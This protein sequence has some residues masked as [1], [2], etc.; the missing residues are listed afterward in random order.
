MSRIGSKPIDVPSGVTVKVTGSKVDV[1]GAKG[2]MSLDV[3]EP[4]S[5]KL[6]GSIVTLSR[7][8][9]VKSVKALH[10]L[11]RSLL[12]NIIEGVSNGFEKKLELIGVGYRASL[13]GKNLNLALGYSHPVKLNAPEGITFEV[14]KK[15]TEIVVKGIDKQL[16]G[17]VA[18]EIRQVRK[19]EPYKGKGVRYSGERVIRKAG[20]SVAAGK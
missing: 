8:S 1:K 7:P 3:K 11:F 20:K 17:Q 15:Q 12:A 18:A 5:V 10:G 4:I 14:S 6:D 2:S 19:V 16:V 13:E 9:D